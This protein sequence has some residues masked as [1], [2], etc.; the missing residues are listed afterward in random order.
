MLLHI[1]FHLFV[2]LSFSLP[3]VCSMFMFF[4]CLVSAFVQDSNENG[5]HGFS[6]HVEKQC[7]DQLVD[8]LHINGFCYTHIYSTFMSFDP[9]SNWAVCLC[10]FQLLLNSNSCYSSKSVRMWREWQPIRSIW[11]HQGIWLLV[12]ITFDYCWFGQYLWLISNN[13]PVCSTT[14]HE[15]KISIPWWQCCWRE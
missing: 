12:S 11:S 14:V 5:K 3:A 7:I 10:T 8:K 1:F 2:Y 13:R 9:Y 6:C 15:F 4:G